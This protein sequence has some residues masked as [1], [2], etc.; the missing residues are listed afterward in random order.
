M[1]VYS[2]RDAFTPKESLDAMLPGLCDCAEIG[3]ALSNLRCGD[4]WSVNHPFTCAQQGDLHRGEHQK[5]N[6]YGAR[7]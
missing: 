4:R 6:W 7:G 2:F 1:S 5:G 3:N